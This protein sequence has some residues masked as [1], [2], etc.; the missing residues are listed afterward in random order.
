MKNVSKKILEEYKNVYFLIAGKEGPLY[1]L[2]H[3]RWI[4][5][6]WIDNPQ[7][8]I[9]AADVFVLPNEETYFDIV[10]L[11]TLAVGKVIIASRTGGNKYFNGKKG[12]FLYDCEDDFFQCI[13]NIVNMPATNRAELEESNKMLFNQYFN[14]IKFAE[15]Y[16]HKISK[17][18]K[19]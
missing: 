18:K 10:L 13:N 7:N 5:V 8:I 14:E 4:E 15:F 17:L 12:I 3:E 1:R 9:N 19:C 11:E 16:V 2:K 6:G